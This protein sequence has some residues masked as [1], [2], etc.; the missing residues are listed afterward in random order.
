[1]CEGGYRF[2]TPYWDHALRR[3]P[4]A[5]FHTP[6]YSESP[7]QNFYL[8]E[9]SR[10]SLCR[11][12]GGPLQ[13]GGS[14]RARYQCS[15]SFEPRAAAV[16]IAGIPIATA[17]SAIGRASIMATPLESEGSRKVRSGA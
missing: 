15:R 17:A 1:M 12:K 11:S 9:A 6:G 5:E 3:D 4:G 16:M 7:S 8:A 10:S 13:G 2:A 14:R